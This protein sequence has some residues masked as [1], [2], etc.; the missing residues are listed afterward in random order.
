MIA[1]SFEALLERSLAR[2]VAWAMRHSAAVLITTV[3]L[4]VGSGFY[5]ARNL[6]I[7]TDTADMLSPRLAWR[8]TYIDYQAAFPDYVD[9]IAIVIDGATPGRAED[10]ASALTASLAARTDLFSDIFDPESDPHFRNNQL[11]YADRDDLATLA[12]RLSA[13]QPFLGTL[14]ADPSLRGLFD[15]LG[16]ALTQTQSDHG[17]PL[18][19]TLT[20]ID[21]A[22]GAMLEGR[23]GALSWQAVMTGADDTSADRR[24]VI[25][26]KPIIDFSE[27]LPGAAAMHGIR[28]AI[29]T[30]P[31]E[32]RRDVQIRRTGSAALGYEELKTVSEGSALASIFA[33]ILIT[34][35]LLV[36]I[37]SIWLVFGTQLVLLVGLTLTTAFA[38]FVIGELNMISVAFAVLFLGLAAAFPI[39]YAL[40]VRELLGSCDKQRAMVDAASHLGSSMALCALATAL[41]FYSFIPTAYRGVAELGVI[42]GTGMIIGFIVNVIVFP[43]LMRYLPFAPRLIDEHRPVLSRVARWPVRHAH[44]VTAVTV[45][46][47][48]GSALLLPRARFNLNPID[49]QDPE[50]ESVRAFRDLLRESSRSP[51]SIAVVAANPDTAGDL[52][53]QLERLPTVAAVQTIDSFVPIDQADKVAIVSD[54]ALTFGNSLD[55]SHARTAPDFAQTMLALNSLLGTLDGV[56]ATVPAAAALRTNLLHLRARIARDDT[57]AAALLAEAEDVLLGDLP[58]RIDRLRDAFEPHEFGRDD[59]PTNLRRRWVAADGRVRLEVFPQEDLADDQAVQRFVADVR[60]IAGDAATDTPVVIVEAAAAVVKA[61]QQALALAVV[62]IAILIWLV[63]RNVREVL[64]SIG[65]LL[66]AGLTTCAGMVLIDQP[67]NFANIIALPLLLGMGVDN[68]LH[69]MHRYRTDLPSDGL[70]LTTSTARAILFDVLTAIAGFGNLILSRHLGTRSMALVLCAG[71]A[72]M[73]TYSLFVLPS[74]LTLFPLRGSSGRSAQ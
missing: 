55:D 23:P 17:L 41:G 9:T 22:L 20:R 30:L 36:G 4:T 3:L 45:I 18:E 11:L 62:S 70:L 28:D 21:A 63:L 19:P 34:I 50:T 26:V 12:D 1:A 37:G 74:L 60:T 10:A 58:A 51:Y 67:F 56:A 40:R 44:A 71:L 7:N 57:G 49:L 16:T 64:L 47:A 15:L 46:I 25:V 61:F 53:V 69:I 13:A 72:V 31:R 29:R 52:R 59:L 33:F 48:L 24:R 8:R 68:S 2:V 32:L 39:H 42:A 14:A 65:P 54:L 6:G 43:A 5:I 27:M 73:I 66:L 38:T 35:C